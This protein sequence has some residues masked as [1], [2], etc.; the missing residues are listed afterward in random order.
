RG[1]GITITPYAAGRII[2]AA[3][4]RVCW[5][6]DDNDIVYATAYNHK[7]ERRVFVHLGPCALG[8][9]SRPSVLITDAHNALTEVK[10]RKSR[11]ARL[12]A[13][14]MDTI[15]GGGNVL[16]PTD[17]AGRV[18]EL[19][20]LLD[21]H[22][23]KNKLG[24]YRLVLLHN[25]AFNTAEYAKSQLE[26]M[27]NEISR[28]F[29]LQRS[30]PFQLHN[31][32]II[33]SLEELDELGKDPKVVLATDMSLDYGFSKALLLR[34]APNPIN[35]ILL[36]GRG[37]GDTT[38]RHLLAQ[39]EGGGGVGDRG[40]GGGGGRGRVAGGGGGWGGGGGG[41]G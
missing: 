30:N 36:T 17:T 32:H 7:T 38:A 10:S 2:G 4:W 31:V 18:L 25:T 5:Q 29:D 33:H 9:L 27:S 16:L 6:T 3:V 39:L 37:H 15:R 1:A 19:L 26:W 28:D 41:R 20:V 24:S 35:A 14:V 8:S 23:K 34:W 13:V 11:E 22:W 40:G 21:G 12:L